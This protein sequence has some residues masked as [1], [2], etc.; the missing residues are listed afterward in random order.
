MK[1]NQQTK[2]EAVARERE[3]QVNVKSWKTRKK[4][5]QRRGMINVV[6]YC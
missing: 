1:V 4:L 3:N 6:K 2:L 5:F